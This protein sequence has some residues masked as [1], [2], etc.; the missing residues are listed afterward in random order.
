MLCKH[1]QAVTSLCIVD[2]YERAGKGW[3]RLKVGAR[4]ALWVA[5][6][7]ARGAYSGVP[8]ANFWWADR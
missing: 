3:R 7:T 4:L 1:V 6:A 8:A 2:E 5:D